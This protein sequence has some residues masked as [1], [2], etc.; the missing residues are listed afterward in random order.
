LAYRK[1]K[2]VRRRL[3]R[4]LKLWLTFTTFLT[5][6]AVAMV[7]GDA[8]LPVPWS[9]DVSANTTYSSLVADI[10]LY[11]LYYPPA[12]AGGDRQLLQRAVNVSLIIDSSNLWFG[13]YRWDP[14]ITGTVIVNKSSRVVLEPGKSYIVYLYEAIS[15]LSA[16]IAIVD[17]GY[18]RSFDSI[19]DLPPFQL[20][21]VFYVNKCD[22]RIIAKPPPATKVMLIRGY[23]ERNDTWTKATIVCREPRCYGVL[24]GC[25]TDVEVGFLVEPI[26]GLTVYLQLEGNRTK[27]EVVVGQS[28][29]IPVAITMLGLVPTTL[30]I[31]RYVRVKS[32]LKRG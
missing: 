2:E 30:T 13:T 29:L 12:I 21:F 23:D 18:E 31:A 28:P 24:K 15:G 19:I 5:L 9:A 22:A 25:Y 11:K 26:P 32:H 10:I 14:N 20:H 7:V 27:A 6:I 16:P 1:L 4:K 3:K 8:R 17:E